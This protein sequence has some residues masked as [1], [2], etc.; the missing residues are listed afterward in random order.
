MHTPGH[1]SLRVSVSVPFAGGLPTSAVQRRPRE[2]VKVR[3][4][5]ANRRGPVAGAELREDFVL[6]LGSRA[7]MALRSAGS[8]MGRSPLLVAGEGGGEGGPVSGARSYGVGLWVSRV[9][10]GDARGGASMF[11]GRCLS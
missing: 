3:S 6:S 10:Q 9:P 7:M 11:G 2:I 4:W 1:R 8:L 5:H